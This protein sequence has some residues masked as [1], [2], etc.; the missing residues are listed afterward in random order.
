MIE[1]PTDSLLFS[2]LVSICRI[3][4]QKGGF[5]QGHLDRVAEHTYKISLKI[6]LSEE[7]SKRIMLA[8]KVHDLGKVAIPEMLLSKPTQLTDEEFNIVKLHTIKGFELLKEVNHDKVISYAKIIILHHHEMWN[9]KGYPFGLKNTDIPLC[10][11][12]VAITDVY[13][14]LTQPRAYKYPW[15]QEQAIDYINKNKEK[16]FDP[17]LVEIFMEVI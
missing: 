1:H 17:E 4:E 9:G 10:A 8:S 2:S 13:D 7:E 16:Q 12:I 11:R 6:G 14:A 3:A 15:T 5:S